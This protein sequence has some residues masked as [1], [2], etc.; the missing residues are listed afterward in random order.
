M[1]YVSR[2]KIYHSDTDCYNVV[3]HG[4]YLKW[5]EAGR[6]ELS[7]KLGIKFAELDKMGILLPVVDLNI[8]YKHSARLFDE[9]EIKTSLKELKKTSVTF[10]HEIRAVNRDKLILQAASTVVT[11]DTEGRLFRS[12]PEYLYE[13]YSGILIT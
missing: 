5:L 1:E 8:R 4:S 2:V 6:V 3:W 9:L 12:M 13:K 11:T 10:A 7:E